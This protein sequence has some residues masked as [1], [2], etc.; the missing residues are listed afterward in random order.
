MQ[1]L[2]EIIRPALPET[3]HHNGGDPIMRS[4]A[5]H[6]NEREANQSCLPGTGNS[7]GL[8][9]FTTCMLVV[10]IS[11]I[12]TSGSAFAQDLSSRSDNSDS[13]PGKPLR[14][15]YEI[16]REAAVSLGVFDNQGRLLRHLVKGETRAAGVNHEFWDGLDQWG[17]VIQAGQ[18]QLKGAYFD[19]L[20]LEYVMTATNP[21]DPPWW[22][23]DGTG[24]WLS[25]QSAAQDIVT[26]GTNVYIAAPGTEAGHGLIA[27][28]PD[29]KRIWA[30]LT[31][32]ED[33]RVQSPWPCLA[34]GSMQCI[35]GRN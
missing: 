18:Y 30:T 9:R 8:W 33:I 2:D 5:D 3:R 23:A 14:I 15:T 10:F 27:V 34:T 21:G 28:G 13:D 31:Q 25:D 32:A 20:R 16:P 1:Q 35:A 11:L 29:G 6:G 26:D 19:P 17:N 24:G 22:N 4:A 12:F 7:A